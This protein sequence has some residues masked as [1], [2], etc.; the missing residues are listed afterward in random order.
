MVF[1]ISVLFTNKAFRALDHQPVNNPAKQNHD[2]GH[3]FVNVQGVLQDHEHEQELEDLL[4]AFLDD[5]LSKNKSWLM[6]QMTYLVFY[7]LDC[8]KEEVNKHVK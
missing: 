4:L 2:K 5:E 8:P 1:H 3:Q 7:L 6:G